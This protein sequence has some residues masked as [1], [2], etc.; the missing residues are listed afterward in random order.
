MSKYASGIEGL[1]YWEFPTFLRVSGSRASTRFFLPEEVA[2]RHL[3]APVRA[4]FLFGVP[5]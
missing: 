5:L 4:G 3:P 2:S 1:A